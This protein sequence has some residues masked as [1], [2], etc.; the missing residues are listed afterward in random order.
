MPCVDC[1]GRCGGSPACKGT[2]KAGQRKTRM[3]CSL[4]RAAEA[5]GVKFPENVGA[6][7]R[8]HKKA[9]AARNSES[10]VKARALMAVR[11]KKQRTIEKLLS[12]ELGADE[13]EI[14]GI[15][16]EVLIPDKFA[17]RRG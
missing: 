13:M 3:L 7:W 1:R 9:D 16:S 8:A 15:K 6:W 2:C 10:A 5:K 17:P 12:L 4:A 14:L 11:K